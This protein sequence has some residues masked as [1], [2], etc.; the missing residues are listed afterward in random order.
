VVFV[1]LFAVGTE[2]SETVAHVSDGDGGMSFFYPL[3]MDVQ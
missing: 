1:V 2:Y 3:F